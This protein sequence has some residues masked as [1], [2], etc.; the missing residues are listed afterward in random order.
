MIAGVV[1]AAGLSR[2][3]GRAK[4]LLP[5]EGKPILRWSVEA[6]Q[7]HVDQLVVVVPPDDAAIRVALDGLRVRFATNPSRKPGKGR[8]SLQGSKRCRWTP[9]PPSSRSVISRGSLMAW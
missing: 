6:L 2:R 4:L 3:M 1:L 7:P 5:L 9:P 8:R